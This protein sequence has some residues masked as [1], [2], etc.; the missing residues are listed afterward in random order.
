M[1]VISLRVVLGNPAIRTTG[2]IAAGGLA[3]MAANLVYAKLL[4]PGDFG[5]LVLLQTIAS[6]TMGLSALG[7]DTLIG[8]KDISRPHKT[9]H[10]LLALCTV[11]GLLLAVFS[12]TVFDVDEVMA[13]LVLTA[14]IGGAATRLY[15]S[16]EQSQQRFARAMAIFQ[17]PQFL[18]L[19]ASLGH[20]FFRSP[21]WEE[22]GIAYASCYLFSL[23]L[24]FWLT[25]QCALEPQ[26]QEDPPLSVQV[27]RGLAIV[28]ATGSLLV[29]NQLEKLIA[30]ETL[31]MVELGALGLASTLVASP[32]KLL[33]AGV[34]YTLLPR[35]KS[36]PDES[37]RR[38]LLYRELQLSAIVGAIGAIILIAVVPA[39]V[40]LIFGDKYRVSY[41]LVLVLV[42][43]GIVRLNSGVINATVNALGDTRTLQ[44]YTL[45]GWVS[46][47]IAALA[48][49]ALADH[50]VVGVVVGVTV[51]W[52]VRIASAAYLVRGEL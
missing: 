17:L 45:I 31:S 43:L 7:F 21:S 33:A 24:G 38:K 29:L 2:M 36:T 46:V 27:S 42:L 52:V 18:F 5:R 15:S 6:V 48:A 35:L 34:G 26:G 22:A 49:Y 11:V 39:A 25:H 23:A 8:R 51:G 50:G 3:F 10:V 13:A 32:F 12:V 40:D 41:A 4:V 9:I 14:S 1:N 47:A 37:D 20:L 30:G 44:I 28:T 19:A 16:I